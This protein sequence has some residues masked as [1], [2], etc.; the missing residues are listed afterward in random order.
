V[1]AIPARKRQQ[2]HRPDKA[3]EIA[4][5]L[6]II[7]KCYAATPLTGTEQLT[8]AMLLERIVNEGDDVSRD[9]WE[10]LRGRPAKVD[11]DLYLAIDFYLRLDSRA[12]KTV[13]SV[14]CAVA[15]DWRL[16]MTGI[17]AS[18]EVRKIA[19]RNKEAALIA[20]RQYQLPGRRGKPD[21][22]RL[23]ASVDAMRGKM[24]RAGKK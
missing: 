10:P 21:V 13:E 3:A 2:R 11:R 16:N 20:I 15:N 14:A 7:G 6:E 17:N 1:T 5:L 19:R 12:D 18:D 4:R 22:Q 8:V 9:F 24:L 23:A